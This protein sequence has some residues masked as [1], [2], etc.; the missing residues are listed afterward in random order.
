MHRCT[1][2]ICDVQTRIIEVTLKLRYE[3]HHLMMTSLLPGATV[4]GL[5]RPSR[6]MMP[7]E[8]RAGQRGLSR[9]RCRR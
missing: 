6:K 9:C 8:M 3:V 5:D 4:L 1:S 7:I 2:C